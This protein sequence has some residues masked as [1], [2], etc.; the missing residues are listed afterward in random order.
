[1]RPGAVVENCKPGTITGIFLY[2]TD[3]QEH[4]VWEGSIN[5]TTAPRR[6]LEAVFAT[7]SYKVASMMVV[8]R[9]DK[10]KGWN[11]IDGFAIAN[12]TEPIDLPIEV[13]NLGPRINTKYS[14]SSPRISPDG[15][16][17]YFIREAH[18]SNVGM[19][20]KDDDQDIWYSTLNDEGEWSEA[21]HL[22]RPLN[23]RTYNWLFSMTADG[24]KLFV[25]GKYTDLG[26]PNGQGVSVS[27]RRLGKLQM[28]KDIEVVDFLN[29]ND[30]ADY[31]ISTDEQILL[32]AVERNDSRGDLDLYVS[33]RLGDRKYGKPISLG[34]TINTR[35]TEGA[36]FL[37][38]DGVTLYFSSDGIPNGQGDTDIW[39]SKRLDDT[40]TNWSEP[41]NLGAPINSS[42]YDSDFS[43]SA[44][45]DYA[46]L[47][48]YEDTY[49][50][51]DV[52]RIPL[53]KSLRPNPVALIR[54]R[55]LN[56]ETKEPIGADIIY[57][58]LPEGSEVGSAASHETSGEYQIILP[59]GKNYGFMGRA[60]GYYPVTENLDLT[61]LTAYEEIERDLYLAPVK[62]G[63]TI[64][65]NN[66]F[67]EFGKATLLAESYPELKRVADL[68]NGNSSIKIELSGHTDN[69][70]SDAA[71]QQL[72]QDRAQSC[73]DY[74]G[75][76]GIEGSRVVVKGYGETQPVAT[77]DTDEGR[78]LNRRV[79][80]KVL[81]K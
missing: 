49:G 53:K 42:D 55:V 52:F 17:L 2:D 45:G 23:N 64:R 18:P 79:E 8:G 11:G 59:Y 34:K 50:E 30:Y 78:A 25:A 62:V 4:K 70:G 9:P 69:V 73:V 44:Q 1:M 58:L 36:P 61:N 27:E 33:K 26:E 35:K 5:N 46:Y 51:G 7:T 75:S 15:R 24:R 38:S 29:K 81:E 68:L 41:Q 63:Q 77:N 80:F 39:M 32:M 16:T 65:L 71:N 21:K 57:E 56:A 40:W 13:E 43:I 12:S 66:I 19:T 60:S 14:D 20:V 28:P 22:G 74:L 67:F 76:L 47:V 10:V 3:G 48:R 31:Y 37:A 72:S 6:I 54:G